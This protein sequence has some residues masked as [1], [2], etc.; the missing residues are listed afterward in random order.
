MF[1]GE[2]DGAGAASVV[3]TTSAGDVKASN[4]VFVV[5]AAFAIFVIFSK[6]SK[7]NCCSKKCV[8]KFGK[9]WVLS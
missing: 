3:A 7:S 8:S 1:Q 2:L 5:D 9:P 6:N 4:A